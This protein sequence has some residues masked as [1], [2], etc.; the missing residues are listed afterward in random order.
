MLRLALYCEG[1]LRNPGTPNFPCRG[2]MPP[3]SRRACEVWLSCD[4]PRSILQTLEALLEEGL[5]PG[6][7]GLLD[8]TL[9]PIEDLPIDPEALRDLAS[10]DAQLHGTLELEY[11]TSDPRSLLRALLFLPGARTVKLRVR[12]KRIQLTTIT[13]IRASTL[14]DLNTRI[15]KPRRIPP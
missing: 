7:V 14:F 3:K 6:K 4:S 15:L 9:I 11:Y 12:Q 2:W 8:G 5:L 13:P 1:T 10:R